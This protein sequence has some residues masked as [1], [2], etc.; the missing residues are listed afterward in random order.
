M[1]Y[2]RLAAPAGGRRFRACYSVRRGYWR[3]A[4]TG[5]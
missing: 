1:D 3:N 4:A 5:K 2:L